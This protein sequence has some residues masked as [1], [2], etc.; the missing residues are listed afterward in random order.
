M[1]AGVHTSEL[2]T[3]I[4]SALEE[5]RWRTLR[6]LAP[7][8]EADLKSQPSPILSPLVWDLAH[9]GHQEELWL[10]RT[11]HGEQPTEQRFDDIYTACEHERS[12]RAELGLLAPT[13]AHDYVAHV[14]GRVL[15]RLPGERF[16]DDEPLR[17]GGYAHHMGIQDQPQ[18]TETMLQALQIGEDRV[19][20]FAEL[21]RPAVIEDG[22]SAARFDGGGVVLGGGS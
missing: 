17:R 2:S 14:R 19:H 21:W 20:P 8:S 7:L 3:R 18:H 15:R 5:A 12:E 1:P 22:P 4:A 11:L 10:L 13:D 9:I 6:A 16:P